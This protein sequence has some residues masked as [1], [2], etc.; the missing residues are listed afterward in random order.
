MRLTEEG[1]GAPRLALREEG[2]GR[3]PPRAGGQG[4]V[5]A[6]SVPPGGTWPCWHH[7]S[8]RS[9][10]SSDEKRYMLLKIISKRDGRMNIVKQEGGV[11]KKN[12]SIIPTWGKHL[13]PYVS[14]LEEQTPGCGR[15]GD[16]CSP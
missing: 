10:I 8:R 3:R 14:K 9:R 15:E 5:H 11:Y 7:V 16:F 2:G 6:P 12:V 13:R 1:L 4:H